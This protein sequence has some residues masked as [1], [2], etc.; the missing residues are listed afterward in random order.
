MVSPSRT[1]SLE[2][3]TAAGVPNCLGLSLAG[4]WGCSAIPLHC[5]LP[6]SGARNRCCVGTCARNCEH[7][8]TTGGRGCRVVFV[9]LSD[10]HHG[11]SRPVADP[12]TTLVSGL[13]S[14]SPGV[15]PTAAR[16]P[17]PMTTFFP[18]STLFVP[19][20]SIASNVRGPMKRPEA[21]INSALFCW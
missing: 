18:R 19:S 16:V 7:Q 15:L 12:G 6:E 4:C 2:L 5:E 13:A 1:L 17:V 14:R 10:R 20:A 21:M 11:D 8:H 9:R 3:L